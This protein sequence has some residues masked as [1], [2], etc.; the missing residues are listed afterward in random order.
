MVVSSTLDFIDL[1]S[2]TDLALALYKNIISGNWPVD[3][4]IDI[5]KFK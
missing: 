3:S 4:Y 1:G 5:N 2:Q